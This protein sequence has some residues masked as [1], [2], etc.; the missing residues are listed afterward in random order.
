MRIHGRFVRALSVAAALIGGATEVARGVAAA[1]VQ[2]AREKPD[3][4]Q[5]QAQL[6]E[7]VERD[8]AKAVALWRQIAEDKA[9]GAEQRAQ[10]QIAIARGLQRLGR[11][12]EAKAAL[13]AAAQAGGKAGEEA[14]RLLKDG[15]GDQRLRERVSQAVAQLARTVRTSQST[16]FTLEAPLLADVYWLGEPAVGE[17]AALVDR[18]PSDTRMASVALQLVLAIGGDEAAALVRRIAASPDVVLRRTLLE[19]SVVGDGERRVPGLDREPIRAALLTL[20]DDAD[21]RVRALALRKLM[22]VMTEAELLARLDEADEAVRAR[23]LYLAWQQCERSTAGGLRS[24]AAAPVSDALMAAV[25]R[26][27][28][29]PSPEVREMATNILNERRFLASGAA[30]RELFLDALTMDSLWTA[31]DAPKTNRLLGAGFEP[32][33]VFPAPSAARLLEVARLVEVAPNASDVLRQRAEAF[34]RFVATCGGAG[35]AVGAVADPWPADHAALFEIGCR[36]GWQA[37]SPWAERH[38]TVA[39]LGALIDLIE[40]SDGNSCRAIGQ[41]FPQFAELPA[42]E[43]QRCIDQLR[44]LYVSSFEKRNF[45]FT[46]FCFQSLLTLKCAA[47]DRAAVQLVEQFP[48]LLQAACAGFCDPRRDPVDTAVLLDLLVIDTRGARD[49]QSGNLVDGSSARRRLV[50][51][52]SERAAPELPERLATAYRIG[53]SG[54]STIS[55]QYG[56]LVRLFA[57]NSE[58][59]SSSARPRWAPRYPA[60]TLAKTLVACAETGKSQF[61]N[62]LAQLLAVMASQVSD[63]AD[64]LVVQVGQTIGSVLCTKLRSAPIEDDPFGSATFARDVAKSYVGGQFAGWEEFALAALDDAQWTES[65]VVALP[66]LTEPLATKAF[67][68]VDRL[69]Y[70][71]QRRL[72]RLWLEA[73]EPALCERVFDGVASGARGVRQGAVEAIGEAFPERLVGAVRGLARDREEV[74]REEV[75]RQLARSFDREAIPLLIELLRDSNETVRKAARESL[76]QLQYY[77]DSKSRWEKLLSESGLDAN[78]AAEALLKQAKSGATI[79]LRKAAIDSLGT[80]KVPETLPFLIQLMSDPDPTLSAAAKAAVL[81]INH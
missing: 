70:P 76:E 22:P 49:P 32:G 44:R 54:S 38:A 58:E 2:Q 5:Q 65:I 66:W 19:A 10:A 50:Q 55:D 16:A 74:V 71:T 15:F 23:A 8:F 42:T 11:V 53:L 72:G 67:A 31:L 79:E 61:W 62:D 3:P 68:Q 39:D 41:R 30:A 78:S 69:S 17:L 14:T 59:N 9:L 46:G 36:V 80:L 33:S 6:A 1:C 40:A 52:L 13:T 7:Q 81:K 43:Q 28:R 64:P 20:C 34:A 29:D 75:A 12:D 35:A 25:R 4:R 60:E 73:S 24:A 26:A 48:E 21:P 56:T 27:C 57:T 45:S 37:V 63:R 51:A 47:A 18:D 77:F